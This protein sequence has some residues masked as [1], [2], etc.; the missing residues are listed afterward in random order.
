MKKALITGITGQGDKDKNCK[1]SRF[2]LP[3]LLF[4]VSFSFSLINSKSK[5]LTLFLLRHHAESQL[6]GRKNLWKNKKYVK[7]NIFEL[8]GGLGI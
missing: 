7:I 8:K 5:D 6:F 2:D 4:F 3:S 1:D